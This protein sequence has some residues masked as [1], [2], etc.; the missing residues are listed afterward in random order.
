LKVISDRLLHVDGVQSVTTQLDSC[1]CQQIVIYPKAGVEPAALLRRM[2]T[3][4]RLPVES[5]VTP[6]EQ[7]QNAAQERPDPL[8]GVLEA[9]SAPGCSLMLESL[10]P[11]DNR[12]DAG[13][14]TWGQRLSEIGYGGLAVASLGMAWVGLLVPGIPTVPFVIVTVAFAA[15]A[16]PA[17]RARLRRAKVFGPMIVDWERHH[18]VRPAVRRKAILVTL[19]LV[20]ITVVLAPPSVGLYGLIGTMS[21]LGIVMIL[22]IPVIQE[23]TADEHLVRDVTPIAGVA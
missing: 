4:L 15:K 12:L 7:V 9:D 2:A 3:A 10:G 13:A 8:V 20:S 17:L 16:S 19:A 11:A 18:G 14:R 22:R 21:I 23:D 6:D 5:P 1:R